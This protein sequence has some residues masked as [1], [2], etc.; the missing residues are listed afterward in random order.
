ML[1]DFTH[2]PPSTPILDE[3]PS[4]ILKRRAED[5][6]VE[7][8]LTPPILS[9]SPMKKLKSVSFTDML[10]QYI[11]DAPRAESLAGD[12]DDGAEPDFDELF[13]DIEPYAKEAITKVEN[14][15]LLGAD[16]TAR[17]EVPSVS[18]AL[19]VSP[20]DEYSKKNMGKHKPDV[21]ELDAQMK[22]LLRIK[23]EDL[24]S[25]SSWHGLSSLERNMQWSIFTTKISKIDLDERLHGEAEVNKL[26]AG[27]TSGSI[28]T[29]SSQVWK[30]EGLRILD[31][32]NEEEEIEPADREGPVQMDDLIRK[33]KR[34]LEI[35]EEGPEEHRKRMV[36]QLPPQSQPLPHISKSH[37][38]SGRVT[39]QRSSKTGSQPDYAQD[40]VAPTSSSRQK[41]LQAPTETSNDLMFGGFSATS[42]LHKFME[43]QG[44][45]VK[46]VSSPLSTNQALPIR[47]REPSLDQLA[48]TSRQRPGQSTA[49]DHAMQIAPPSLPQLPDLPQNL[50]QCSV[51]VSSAFLQQRALLKRIEKLH[52]RAEIIYRDYDRP[53]SPCKEADIVLSPSTGLVL[54][55]LQQLKQ[56]PLPGQPDRSRVEESVSMLQLRYERLVVIISEGLTNDMESQGSSRPDDARD[57]EALTR[58]E[59]FT[60]QLEGEVIAKYIPGGNQAL[61]HSIVIEMTNYG[62]PHGSQDIGDIKPVAIETTVSITYQWIVNRL[63]NGSKVGSLP[64]TY[65]NQ[66]FRR[67]SHG[68]LAKEA[69]RCAA[70][71]YLEF[72]C[73]SPSAVSHC[74]I[75]LVCVSN[76][77][78]RREGG[79]LSSS[80]GRKPDSEESEQ[81]V[82]S[83]MD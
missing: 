48:S 51:I 52:Q 17:A 26:L 76:H 60:S 33:R 35:E 54:T 36:S 78:R 16:T 55:T 49:D 30:P 2:P 62:L 80:Y 13:K 11:P 71:R 28:A 47:S 70:S 23:R 20:W 32:E 37:H 9:D 10:H 82:G 21:T 39:V 42:A 27:M 74:R 83:G 67:S 65:R 45:A 41:T 69:F 18:F 44:R 46:P 24:Q 19:P 53:H 38:W 63:S 3:R 29:S 43:T 77:E 66:S 75:W 25:A 31:A 50:K 7:G 15:K 72:A 34:K 56:R 6:K 5:L 4:A 57:K 68:R 8:P 14:E 1:L 59:K 81:G 79:V 64:S 40:C 73:S 12:E 22:F 58:F 61:A